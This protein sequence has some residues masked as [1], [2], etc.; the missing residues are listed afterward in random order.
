MD[1][2]RSKNDEIPKSVFEDVGMS[3]STFRRVNLSECTFDGVNLGRCKIDDVSLGETRITRSCFTRLEI[4]GNLTE[5]RMNGVP[6]QEMMGA[7]QNA[8][9]KRFS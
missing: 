1:S 4:D 2:I 3:G 5:M 7:W 9:G 8:T 6:L